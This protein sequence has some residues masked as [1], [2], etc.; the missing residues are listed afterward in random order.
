MN[1]PIAGPHI[2]SIL[3]FVMMTLLSKKKGAYRLS[4]IAAKERIRPSIFL[5]QCGM[6]RDK[7]WH[8]P[9]R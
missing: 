3:R 2:F 1:L 5:S 4:P 9:M 8:V 7:E 6:L